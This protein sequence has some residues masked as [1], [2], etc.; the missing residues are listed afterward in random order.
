MLRSAL[1]IHELHAIPTI[2]LCN[3]AGRTFF[4]GPAALILIKTNLFECC[5]CVL[6]K[7]PCC[8]QFRVFYAN[9]HAE[10]VKTDGACEIFQPSEIIIWI[11]YILCHSLAILVSRPL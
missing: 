10:K 5:A 8:K 4:K 9:M 11:H 6:C 2:T 1:L 3:T 7:S